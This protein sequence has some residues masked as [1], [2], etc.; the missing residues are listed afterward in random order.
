MSLAEFQLIGEM[1]RFVKFVLLCFLLSSASLCFAGEDPKLPPYDWSEYPRYNLDFDYAPIEG[2]RI[3]KVARGKHEVFLRESGR[4]RKAN[5]MASKDNPMVR[6]QD[7]DLF[8]L[9]FDYDA[10]RKIGGPP[11]PGIAKNK[12]RPVFL[13]WDFHDFSKRYNR[14]T[15]ESGFSRKFIIPGE[16]SGIDAEPLNV[17]TFHVE[18]KSAEA[19]WQRFLL[20]VVTAEG[21]G[22]FM[23]VNSFDRGGMTVGFIQMAA[24]TPNDL[25]PMMK[26]LIGSEKLRGDKYADP[27]R[28]FPELGITKTGELGFRKTGTKGEFVSLEKPTPNRNSNEGFRRVP[29]WA[30]WYREDFVRFCNPDC[31][32]INRAELHFAARWLMWSMSPKM[33][34]AQVK[35]SKDNVIR[36]LVKLDVSKKSV[37][38]ADAAIAAVILHWNDS[39]VYQAK[40]QQLLA[41]PNPVTSFL[42]MESRAGKPGA[43]E[44]YGKLLCKE[45]SWFKGASD[46]ERQI[47]NNRIGSVRL[48]FEENPGLLER[49]K[50]LKF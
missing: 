48:V 13:G 35:P 39:Q 46:A 12:D 5:G 18:P 15:G 44:K 23:I 36:T 42:G 10:Y 22:D 40:V 6:G 4:S 1:L 8:L 24:H 49:L 41:Q 38:A 7:E 25:I 16:F 19:N 2:W 50:K 33:R 37:T 9:H 45:S 11:I 29:A 30:S 21:M 28:W 20:P 3:E 26:H 31:T 34:D 32:E 17:R 27:R 47:L 14:W 43:V